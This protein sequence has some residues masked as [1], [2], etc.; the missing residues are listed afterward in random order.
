[1]NYLRMI[2]T[3]EQKSLYI[4]TNSLPAV[5]VLALLLNT[6]LKHY[7]EALPRAVTST[8]LSPAPHNRVALLLDGRFISRHPPLLA[9]EELAGVWLGEGGG[10][11]RLQLDSRKR[12][13]LLLEEDCVHVALDAPSVCKVSQLYFYIYYTTLNHRR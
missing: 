11:R 2:N 1:M 8:E 4:Y 10:L 5:A 6:G 13:L 9:G 3:I 7:R 12:L